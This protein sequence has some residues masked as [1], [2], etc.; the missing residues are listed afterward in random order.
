MKSFSHLTARKAPRIHSGAFTL[1]ELLVVIGI[2]A[3][4]VGILLPAL[5]KAR[6]AAATVQCA[7][8]MKQ[9]ANAMLMYINNNRGHFPPSQI[10]PDAAAGYPSGWWWP[11]ELVRGK[12]I[13]APSVY[14][15]AGSSINEKRFGGTNVFKCPEGTDQDESVGGAGAYPTD[16][17]N[18][19]YTLPYDPEHATA[20]FG[21]PSWYQLCSRTQQ[22]SGFYPSVSSKATPFMWFDGGVSIAIKDA[23]V[24]PGFQ[25]NISMIRK[26]TEVVM[27]VE[28]S[29]GNWVDQKAS[30]DARYASYIF[31]ARLGARHGKKT[32]D[33]ANA[34]TNFAFF[35]GH[36]GLFATEPYTHHNNNN[37][38]TDNML[39]DYY[40]DT[41]FYLSKQK[42]KPG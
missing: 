41:I 17:K 42:G 20:G 23:F 21:I 22:T 35:D 40:R 18:N 38:G 37:T 3:V 1:V 11:D 28:A 33:G 12:Y 27:I 14:D 19:A 10:N 39:V 15:H 9:V 26:P 6:R 13:N 5:N 32:A 31:L 16:S 34:Y 24:H 7:S 8:N 30:T 29:N 36:V 2:I 4:L 25:R